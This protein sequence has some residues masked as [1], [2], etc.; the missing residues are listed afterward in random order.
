MELLRAPDSVLACHRVRHEK[1]LGRLEGVLQPG[2]FGHELL[3]DMEPSGGIH[4]DHVE[5]DLTGAGERGAA[6]LDRLP[7]GRELVGGDRSLTGHL[8][9]LETGCGSVNVG[10]NEQGVP[11]LS[12]QDQPKFC[13]RGGLARALKPNQQEHGRVRRRDAERRVPARSEQLDQLV[14]DNLQDLISGSQAPEDLLAERLFPHPLE[15]RLRDGDCHIGFQQREADF[16]QRLLK[17]RLGD[18][19]LA[20]QVP[21]GLLELAGKVLEHPFLSR[22]PYSENSL[23]YKSFHS[24]QS[25]VKMTMNC[26][27]NVGGS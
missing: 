1:H 22:S 15:Q 2:Q 16:P 13:R 4:N 25:R 24:C 23:F 26:A 6:D 17:R 5:A 7:T 11:A 19:S 12:L 10:R 3:V 20:G 21:K 18:P 9:E 8:E 27:G 14:P